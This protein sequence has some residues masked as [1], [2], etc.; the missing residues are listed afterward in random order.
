MQ[1]TWKSI[2][3]SNWCTVAP[4]ILGNGGHPTYSGVDDRYSG[5]VSLE[6]SNECFI[7]EPVSSEYKLDS[8]TVGKEFPVVLSVCIDSVIIVSALIFVKVSSLAVSVVKILICDVVV[9]S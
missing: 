7:V 5:I 4:E 8:N 9:P 3:D 6:V 1:T 2:E